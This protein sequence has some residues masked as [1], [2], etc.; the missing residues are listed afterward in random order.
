MTKDDGNIRALI[1]YKISSH[2]YKKSL[3]GDKTIVIVRSSYLHNVISYTGKITSL[4]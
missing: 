4:Y 1:Q 3:C 2:Q